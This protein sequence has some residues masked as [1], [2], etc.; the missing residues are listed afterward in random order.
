MRNWVAFSLLIIATLSLNCSDVAFSARYTCI[1]H[2][3]QTS[4]NG[5]DTC[6]FKSCDSQ[7]ISNQTH[8]DD[9]G[10]C[11]KYCCPGIPPPTTTTRDDLLVTANYFNSTPPVMHR[12]FSW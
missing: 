8:F 7:L 6:Q 1:F 2:F 5:S 12:L 11:Y 9:W 3:I 4:T 10:D